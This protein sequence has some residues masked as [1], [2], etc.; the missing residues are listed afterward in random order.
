[1]SSPD[2]S[3]SLG[4]VPKLTKA[5]Q[6][7]LNIIKEG[8][9]STKEISIRRKTTQRNIQKIIQNIKKKGVLGISSPI[10]NKNEQANEL[11]GFR[12]HAEQFTI[13]PIT[14]GEKYI[15]A[16]GKKL[17]I[18]GNTILVH[19]DIVQYYCN[20]SFFGSDVWAATAKSMDYLNR[21]V[22]TLENELQS[23]LTKPRSQNIERVKSE[24]AHIQNGLAVKMEREGEKIRIRADEDGHVWFTIDNSWNF[25]EAETHGKT[26]QRDMQKVIEAPFND[27]RTNPFYLPSDTKILVDGLVKASLNLVQANS[28]IHENLNS[29]LKLLEVQTRSTVALAQNIEAHIPSWM[30]NAKVELELKRLRRTISLR[31]KRLGEFI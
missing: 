1:M 24:Y 14:K 17:D 18:D 30:S 16:I 31:Q 7:V 2:S 23:I 13:E 29:Q 15:K 8:I 27:M 22:N 20:K 5:E 12:L 11:N 3:P 6:E 9:I 26:A 19:N 21:I 25:K 10:A 28:N 4:L